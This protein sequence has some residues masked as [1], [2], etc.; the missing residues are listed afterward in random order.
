MFYSKRDFLI[1]I[2]IAE[3][4]AGCSSMK[5]MLGTQVDQKKPISNPFA[6]YRRSD[7]IGD[8]SQNII[9]RTKKGDRSV[10]VELPSEAERL[11][12]FVVPVSP[13][14]QEKGRGLASSN[15]PQENLDET[16]K[17]HAPTASD[18]EITAKFPQSMAEDETRRLQ[19]EQSL[20][21]G[22]TNEDTLSS[23]SPSYLARLD[24]IK[25]LY[26]LN[27]YEVA[28]LETD[29]MIKSYQTDAKLH[30]MRGTLLDR[31]GRREMALKSWRQA[32][33]FDP[34]NES[35]KRFIDR[36]Q[37]PRNLAGGQ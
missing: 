1:L 19:L 31:L 25:Q 21:L 35:L 7:G 2:V 12:D 34:Q 16:Y 24:R 3:L 32:L 26:R 20:N 8:S 37:L 5:S 6:D 30:E 13:A 14:F 23:T 11:S 15:S 28:L 33:R 27:R 18:R 10:E 22:P 29:E 17:E 9:L 36:K 4:L